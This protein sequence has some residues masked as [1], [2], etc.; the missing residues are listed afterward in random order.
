MN[1]VFLSLIL[2]TIFFV[3]MLS[4][5]VLRTLKEGNKG[6]NEIIEKSAQRKSKKKI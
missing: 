3:S 5:L 2:L 1:D 6:L 4:W